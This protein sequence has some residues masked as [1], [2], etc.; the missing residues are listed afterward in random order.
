MNNYKK[1]K[2]LRVLSKMKRTQQKSRKPI[3]NVIVYDLETFITNR[4]IQ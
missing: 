4:A 1:V 2:M 3:I